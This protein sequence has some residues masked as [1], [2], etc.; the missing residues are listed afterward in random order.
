M[1]RPAIPAAWP[2]VRR[3]GSRAQVIFVSGDP[4]GA[5][6]RHIR[7]PDG[8]NVQLLRVAGRLQEVVVSAPLARHSY[9]CA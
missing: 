6:P 2:S 1:V 3:A 7:V 9:P 8:E 5:G 4:V